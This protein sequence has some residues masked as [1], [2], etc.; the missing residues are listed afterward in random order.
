MSQLASKRPTNEKEAEKWRCCTTCD[1]HGPIPPSYDNNKLRYVINFSDEYMGHVTI[2]GLKSEAAAEVAEQQRYFLA[3]TGVI[4]QM[5]CI[6]TDYGG[7]LKSY[8][9]SNSDMK[10]QGRRKLSKSYLV[11]IL[12]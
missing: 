5:D 12:T 6:P 7:E 8:I 4:G 11:K 1:L 10:R 2:H 9:E 3:D